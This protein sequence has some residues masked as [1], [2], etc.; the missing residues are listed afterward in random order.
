MTKL[1]D[2]SFRPNG[3]RGRTILTQDTFF[4]A[5]YVKGYRRRWEGDVDWT[6][7]RASARA[8]Y[9]LVSDDR[10][11]QGI[12]DEDLPP[13]R[14]RSWYVTGTWVVTGEQKKRPL[15][16]ANEFLTGGGAGAVELAVR[17][18]RLWFDSAG[19]T[20]IPS[21]GTRAETIRASG[22]R[23]LTLGVNWTLNRFMKI[24]VNGIRE[25]VEDVERSPVPDTAAFWSR[26]LRLQFVL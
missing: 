19:G 13:A 10:L 9:T 22:D 12:G 2:D 18:E 6:F 20:D 11:K 14:A 4:E 23:A 7:G 26:I 17:Y 8:E 16:A 24:Q 21:R 5:V 1:S 15:R 25:H 3:L